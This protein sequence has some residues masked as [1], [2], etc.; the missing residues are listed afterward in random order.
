MKY[1]INLELQNQL[2]EALKELDKAHH[3]LQL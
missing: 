1:I 2:D 3:N